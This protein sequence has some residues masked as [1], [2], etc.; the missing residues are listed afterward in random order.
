MLGVALADAPCCCSVPARPK[1]L[2]VKIITPVPASGKRV[3]DSR[4][5]LCQGL[6]RGLRRGLGSGLMLMVSGAPE[7]LAGGPLPVEV[8]ALLDIHSARVSS[9]L[10]RQK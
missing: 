10:W 1:M 4:W 7:V 6:R 8:L 9:S 3:T 2:V 5:G